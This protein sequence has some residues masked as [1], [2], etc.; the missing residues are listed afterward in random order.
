MKLYQR[1]ENERRLRTESEVHQG[2][3]RTLPDEDPQG[4]R[5]STPGP[6]NRR[7]PREL[8]FRRLTRGHRTFEGAREGRIYLTH[9]GTLMP[10]TE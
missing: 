7:L 8:P 3:I 6:W 4:K 1:S 9:T 10:E 5:L 2:T